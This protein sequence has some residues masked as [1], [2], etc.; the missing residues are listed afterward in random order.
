MTNKIVIKENGVFKYKEVT[1]KDLIAL[2]KEIGKIIE[3]HHFKAA[4]AYEINVSIDIYGHVIIK[5]KEY[6]YTDSICNLCSANIGEGL[7]V[8]EAIA[9]NLNRLLDKLD[10]IE[11][12]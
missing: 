6:T 10:D 8:K 5:Y 7:T 1:D 4:N 9:L 2:Q 12:N 3:S 11:V